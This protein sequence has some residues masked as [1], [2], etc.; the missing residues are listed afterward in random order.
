MDPISILMLGRIR[1]Q[2]ML[3]EADKARR[4]VLV[5]PALL[6]T[7][8]LINIVRDAVRSARRVSAKQTIPAPASDPLCEPECV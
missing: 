6:W 8:A 7:T 2:E 5:T 3:D 1:Q 4:G